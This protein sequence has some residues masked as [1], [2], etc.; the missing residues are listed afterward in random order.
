MTTYVFSLGLIPVQEWIEKARRSR[1]L[2]AGSVLLCHLMAGVLVHLREHLKADIRLPAES[3]D[4]PDSLFTDLAKDFATALRRDYGIP[5]RASGYCEAQDE[6][7][8]REV[9]GLLE[10]NVVQVA[11]QKLKAKYLTGGT[12]VSGGTGGNDRALGERFW[13]NLAELESYRTALVTAEDCPVSLVWVARP[14]AFPREDLRRNLAD[15]DR[16]YSEVKRS[17]PLRPWPFGQA[18]G[19]CNQC[20][21]REAIGPTSSFAGWLDWHQALGEETA[22]QRGVRFDPGERLC[23]VCLTRRLAGYAKE[24]REGFPSTGEMAAK[25]WIEQAET[26]PRLRAL[27]AELRATE[28]GRLDLARALFV[29]ANTLR[30]QGDAAAAAVR[31]R[32]DLRITEWNRERGERRGEK[33]PGPLPRRPPAYLAL[34]AFDGDDMGRHVRQAPEEMPA[35]MQ[36]FA[37]TAKDLLE[38]HGAEPFYLA[39]DEGLAMAPAGRALDLALA[40]HRAFGE[41]FPTAPAPTL[42]LGIAFFEYSQPMAGALRAV[43]ETLAAAKR[44][45]GKNALGVAVQTAS[46]SRWSIADHWGAP[47]D[48]VGRAVGWVRAGQLAGG[49]AYDVETFLGTLPPSLWEEADLSPVRDEVRRLFFRRFEAA[50]ATAEIRRRVRQAAWETLRPAEWWQGDGGPGELRPRPEQFHLIGFLARQGGVAAG[51]DDE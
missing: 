7:R 33:R 37:T 16:L 2:R 14:A 36:R 26:D 3:P 10:R 12:G 15:V 34:L 9:F 27:L 38:K 1:D 40:L 8:I 49:W 41:V 29:A 42:S 48:G 45:P 11:W 31:D 17:R 19:K 35:R 32:I 6:V 24:F 28:T 47:W 51:R 50:G 22:V 25:P 23:Y 5:N 4:S 46:G 20:G 18:I 21:Q 13:R 39:G 43:H 44:L 30:T